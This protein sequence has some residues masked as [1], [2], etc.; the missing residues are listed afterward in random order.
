MSIEAQSIDEDKGMGEISMVYYL[1]FPPVL[2]GII[3]MFSIEVKMLTTSKPPVRMSK[4]RN[5]THKAF[6]KLLLVRQ[7]AARSFKTSVESRV[8]N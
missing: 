7:T 4:R 1:L 8:E 5:E 6:S 3:G 2:I